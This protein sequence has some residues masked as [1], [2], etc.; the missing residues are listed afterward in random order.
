[1][2]AERDVATISEHTSLGFAYSSLKRGTPCNSS[3][4][5][6]RARLSEGC[7]IQFYYKF[8]MLRCMLVT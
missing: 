3:L 1:M 2:L 4:G 7:L 5:L 6:A 8:N